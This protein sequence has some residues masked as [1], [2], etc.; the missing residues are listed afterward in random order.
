MADSA[1]LHIL[2]TLGEAGG[3]IGMI[4]GV[5]GLLIRLIKRNGCTMRCYHCNGNPAVEIDCEEGAATKR[6]KPTE[7]TAPIRPRD[8]KLSSDT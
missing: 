5:V 2:T 7:D 1:G 3:V 8:V 4:G 6:Y